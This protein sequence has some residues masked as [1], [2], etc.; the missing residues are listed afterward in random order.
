MAR[1]YQFQIQL[2]NPNRQFHPGDT[3]RGN[4]ALE[5]HKSMT[6]RDI[7]VL[8]SGQ[9]KSANYKY[10]TQY[11]AFTKRYEQRKVSNSIG[12]NLFGF[13]T[14]VFPPPNLQQHGLAEEYTL[15]E[16]KYNYPFEL[17]FPNGTVE[18]KA[19]SHF[20]VSSS[21][22][23]NSFLY[24]P[25]MP[26]RGTQNMGPVTV[27]L[28]PS[29]N[30]TQASDDY[31]IVEYNVDARV[32][33]KGWFKSDVF[34]R[35][36]LRFSPRL[37][38][39]MFSFG[40]LMS[41]QGV[42]TNNSSF[43][44]NSSTGNA[45]LKF[46]IEKSKRSEGRSFLRRVFTSRSVKIPLELMVEFKQS[47][48]VAYPQGTT[49]RVLHQG[50]NLADT[51]SLKLFTAFSSEALQRMLIGGD[52]KKSVPSAPLS[53]LKVK[54]IAVSLVHLVY[55]QGIE[56]KVQAR[57][58]LV[59]KQTFQNE[60]EISDFEEVEYWSPDLVRKVK[61][62]YSAYFET[63]KAFMLE[64]P[65]EMTSFILHSDFQSFAAPNILVDY[66][67]RINMSVSTTG[68]SPNLAE[69]VCTAPIVFLPN[70]VDGAASVEYHPPPNPPL[71]TP[72]LQPPGAAG[73]DQGGQ[74]KEEELPAYSEVGRA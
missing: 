55:Y 13:S 69:L 25:N 31:A 2:E 19:M 50:D 26:L 53:N 61:Q 63:G 23:G 58:N 66:Q 33:R 39:V 64:I 67:L 7:T 37:D 62:D 17:A 29:F 41:S 54:K 45:R 74:A 15:A 14:K 68:E 56:P 43:I 72:I 42:S 27:S 24:G 47:N 49:G 71:E 3:V 21:Y 6:V 10:V 4:V 30:M 70:R 9:C 65:P 60:F 18:A 11:N 52:G 16:G 59:G 46:D 20:D 32:D 38:S 22:L 73:P 40:P 48:T 12:F 1:S 57:E 28:P 5:V 51:V 35:Q 34:D 8:L 36:Q 44:A